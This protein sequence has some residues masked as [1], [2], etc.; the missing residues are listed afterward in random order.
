MTEREQEILRL[1]REDP[2]IPQQTLADRLGIS[3]S[4]LASHISSLMR[5]GYVLGR[6]YVLREGPYAVVLGGANMDI[7]GKALGELRSGD[8]NPGRVHTAAGGVARNIAENLA[9]LGSDTRLVT[10]VG[11]D[12]YGQR[13]IEVSQ[14]AGINMR[15]TLVLDGLSTSCYLSLHD[16]SGEMGCAIN[17]MGILASLTPQRL[18]ALDGQMSAASAL[19]LDTNLATPTLAW[20]FDR[21]G[22]L[23]LFVDTVSVA[24][25]EKIRPWLPAIH[26]LK[27]NRLEAESLCG[28]TIRGPQDGP[29]VAEWFHRAGVRRL[30]L[31][32]GEQGIFYSDGEHQEHLS[33]LPCPVINVTGGGDAFMGGLV[34][35]WLQDYSLKYTARFALAC[36][37]LA[38]GCEDT[39]FTGLSQAAAERMLE[40]YPC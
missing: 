31:S 20:L 10:A 7:C 33:I 8:S 23:P 2:M 39:V 11:N 18:T 25:V 22:H 27:P 38:V 6:G 16:S 14:Q 35:A 26:T 24:K 21:Y 17:D 15:H 3:R 19:V 32:L 4:A 30:F 36:S 37:A 5:Q 13:L 34:H 28:I 9:R 40:E 1:L 12:P 29:A